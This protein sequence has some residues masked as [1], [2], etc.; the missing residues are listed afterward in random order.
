MNNEKKLKTVAEFWNQH[1][2]LEVPKDYWT[3]H[4]IINEY[5]NTI[6]APE[7][8]NILEWF[9][10]NF[11]KDKPFDRGLSLGCGTGAADR[12][13]IQAGLCL[14]IEGIDISQASI[15]VARQE[16]LKAGMGNLLQ[17]RVSDLNSIK[18][19]E[20]RY[21]FALCVGSLHHIEKLEH[22][23]NELKTALKPGAYML[24]NEYVG[25]SR[26]QWTEKQLDILNRV[27]EIM[28]PEFRKAG[29]LSAVNKE[30]LIKVDPSEAVRSSYIVPLLYEHFE[31]A[32]HIE[33][34]GSFLMPFWS[35]GVVPDVFLEKP[36]IE[37]QVIVKLLCIIDEL[38]IEEKVLPSCYIQIVARN[39]PPANS[40]PS[41]NYLKN[42]NRKRWTGLW[43]S[44]S[45]GNKKRS[46][47][48]IKKG[49]YVLK[50]E[51]F[52]S[53]LRAVFRYLKSI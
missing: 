37:R 38:I 1:Y 5:V 30:E 44:L 45:G 49:F 48:L 10:R 34:G 20:G 21:D 42:N 28:P 18:L 24:I 32:A 29:P 7:S 27:W 12:Q 17:Y 33:Y 23:F 3:C 8:S 40:R 15:E 19:P 51:G 41:S 9:A 14:F 47:G 22:I 25:P 35:Q 46:Y 31:V 36:S 52:H 6:I 13:A 39:N 4:P 16:A 53:L 2:K 43:L 50:T 26:L 11:T